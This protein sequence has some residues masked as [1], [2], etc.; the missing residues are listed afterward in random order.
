M[1]ADDFT[2]LTENWDYAA[3]CFRPDSVGRDTEVEIGGR[4]YLAEVHGFKLEDAVRNPRIVTAQRVCVTVNALLPIEEGDKTFVFFPGWS[5]NALQWMGDPV[6]T[7]YGAAREAGERNVRF[8]GVNSVGRGTGK[9]AEN[10]GGISATRLMDRPQDAV[11]MVRRLIKDEIVGGRVSLL[12]HSVGYFE[13]MAVWEMLRETA[14]QVE[15]VIALMPAAD[16][17]GAYLNPGW[18]KTTAPVV[19]EAIQQ[20]V[21]RSGSLSLNS[22]VYAESMFSSIDGD[23]DHYARSVPDSATAF[24]D[25][26]L[27]LRRR[28]ADQTRFACQSSVRKMVVAGGEDAL[29]T[30]EMALRVASLL[31][32]EHRMLDNF[33]HSIPVMMSDAQRAQFR[34]VLLTTLV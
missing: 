33:A 31:N 5:G 29:I 9:Y 34:Q 11:A 6:S 8:V 27:N 19:V 25:L 18:L 4:P 22:E 23:P 12:S 21:N 14:V 10:S 7:L 1:P 13:M 15:E 20:Y 2:R 32:A 26:T 24:V 3:Q 17:R 16:L 28:F 30:P